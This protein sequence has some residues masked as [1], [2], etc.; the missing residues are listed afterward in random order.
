[1]NTEAEGVTERI[2]VIRER[3]AVRYTK[4]AVLQILFAVLSIILSFLYYIMVISK[5]TL[6]EVSILGESILIFNISRIFFGL[7]IPYALSHKTPK[8]VR[9]GRLSEAKHLVMILFE[10]GLPLYIV[11]SLTTALCLGLY[12]DIPSKY[13]IFTL[14]YDLFFIIFQCIM[15]SYQAFMELPK[16]SLIDNARMLSYYF[17]IIGLFYVFR[18]LESIYYGWLLSILVIL[19]LAIVFTPIRHIQTR[20]NERPRESLRDLLLFGLPQYVNY[21]LITL[22]TYVDQFFVAVF[23]TSEIFAIYY[24]LSR[25]TKNIQSVISSIR[26]GTVPILSYFTGEKE[27]ES[28]VFKLFFKFVLIFATGPFL[29]ISIYSDA[30]IKFLLPPVYYVGVL[31]LSLLVLAS[32]LTFIRSMIYAMILA[33]G[34]IKPLPLYTLLLLLMRI[35][36]MYMLQLYGSEGI[37]MA[38]LISEC[39]TILLIYI[40][41]RSII[42]IDTKFLAK[43]GGISL[44]LLFCSLRRIGALFLE[45][46]IMSGLLGAYFLLLGFFR[47]LEKE[48]INYLMGTGNKILR[49]LGKFF[50]ILG[51]F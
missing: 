13:L 41:Y 16:S 14:I 29:V 21:L 36:S 28:K 43:L 44:I 49:I 9:Q 46:V 2:F 18:N 11:L 10:R 38:V 25:I 12:L 24:V 30:I 23:F 4:Y 35:A 45:F 19:P 26:I 50:Y 34:D 15:V 42:I 40:K 6:L 27:K 17:F 5:M 7:G 32:F 1:M 22:S 3:L 31:T 20:G 39:V 48:E 37:A 51:N 8:L 47:V 33:Y